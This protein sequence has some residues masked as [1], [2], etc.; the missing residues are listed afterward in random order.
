[1]VPKTGANAQGKATIR[2]TMHESDRTMQKDD[3]TV[4][5]KL[6]RDRELA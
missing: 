6:T 1:M 4:I 5:G 2:V 3:P